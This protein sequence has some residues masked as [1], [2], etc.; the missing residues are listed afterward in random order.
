MTISLIPNVHGEETGKW[1]RKFEHFKMRF[2]SE[3]WKDF[4]ARHIR[5]IAR[6]KRGNR[7]ICET[8]FW[9]RGEILLKNHVSG[10]DAASISFQRF[11]AFRSPSSGF[12]YY[13]ALLLF[14]ESN[15]DII[16]Y[17]QHPTH[18]PFVVPLWKVKNIW[19][20]NL[21]RR[22]WADLGLEMWNP[23]SRNNTKM[24]SDVDWH[25]YFVAVHRI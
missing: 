21:S 23:L 9:I 10:P 22:I 16:K 8:I 2:I 17:I 5:A 4:K 6:R 25:S 24:G 13:K 15:G 1:G 12:L 3:T 20:W 14:R 11:N 7:H 18:L 19:P